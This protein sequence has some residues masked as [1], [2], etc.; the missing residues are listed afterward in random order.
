MDCEEI[1]THLADHL[2]GTLPPHVA[3]EV[4]DHLRGCA[5]CGAE[6]Q[7]LEDTWQ[8]LGTIPSERPDSAEM[9]ARFRAMLDGYREGASPARTR[10]LA[11][12]AWPAPARFAAW[13]SSAAALL[14]LGAVL[15][16][17]TAPQP[18]AADP[19]IAALRDELRDMRQMVTLSLLQQQSASER[20]KGVTWT[21]QI[22]QPSNEVTAAL[23]DT[24]LHDPNDNVRLRT[25]DALKRFADHETVRRGA[26]DALAQ[27]T[28]P[29]VQVAL[30]DFVLEVGGRDAADALRR[31][32]GDPM[33]D[34]AVRARA[35][36]GLARLGA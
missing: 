18:P 22:D 24:L 12:K 23:L 27:Q 21:G 32:S 19:Q 30:I 20:L 2:T 13:M 35:A 16:R 9:R 15:G 25:V 7:G 8:M 6:M 3:D 33:V 29:I 11:L 5:A 14:I 31:L 28:S 10:P 1:R 4:A 26:I 17:Q 34:E 36:Q